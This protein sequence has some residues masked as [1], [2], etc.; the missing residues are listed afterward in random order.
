MLDPIAN[1]SAFMPNLKCYEMLFGSE[2]PFQR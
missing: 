1:I 2:Y